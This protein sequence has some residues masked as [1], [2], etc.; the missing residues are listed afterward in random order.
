MVGMLAELR[1]ADASIRSF[2]ADDRDW[3]VA[4][5]GQSP[6]RGPRLDRR[7]PESRLPYS[8]EDDAR[9]QQGEG[10][11]NSARD[12]RVGERGED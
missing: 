7:G 6:D 9:D 11:A 12:R 2:A 10:E 8:Q 1:S 4:G 5:N 3:T